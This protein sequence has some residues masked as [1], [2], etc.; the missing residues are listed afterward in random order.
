MCPKTKDD[1]E[2]P[3]EAGALE[4]TD[5][6]LGSARDCSADAADTQAS[7]SEAAAAYG[8]RPITKSGKFPKTAPT[9]KKSS[10]KPP[11]SAREENSLMGSAAQSR[12]T[13]VAPRIGKKKKP[14][15]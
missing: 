5:E 7:P 3:E 4:P 6:S 11:T 1:R 15:E 9:S 12:Y 10:T 2:E 14:T 8:R 13:F